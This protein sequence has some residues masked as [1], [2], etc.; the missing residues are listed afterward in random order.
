MKATDARWAWI[1]LAALL[2]VGG[3]AYW[4]GAHSHRITLENQPA[5]GFPQ[6]GSYL[7]LMPE[8]CQNTD[9]ADATACI[10]SY[11]SSTADKAETRTQEA[12]LG[13]R[14]QVSLPSGYPIFGGSDFAKDLAIGVQRAERTRQGYIDTLCKL[15]AMNLYGGS[16]IELE[17]GACE[18][19]NEVLYLDVLKSLEGR[20]TATSS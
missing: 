14:G 16:A 11:A 19:Y 13:N 8:D 15:D 5:L 20:L 3:G 2:V 1:T 6:P 18:Y 17:V 12:I 10:W 4:L 7:T 9:T